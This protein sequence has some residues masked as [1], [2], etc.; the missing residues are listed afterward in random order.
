MIGI[1]FTLILFLSY[2]PLL[3]HLTISPYRR[4]LRAAQRVNQ[5]TNSSYEA[6]MMTLKK[7]VEHLS[8]KVIIFIRQSVYRG[9]DEKRWYRGHPTIN[10]P[11][12][13]RKTA[14]SGLF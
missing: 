12:R 14:N 5:T 9:I 7:E 11:P 4:V 2:W 6:F 10:S 13:G 1:A 8:G 3:V